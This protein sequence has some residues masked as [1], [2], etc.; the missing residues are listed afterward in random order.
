MA[1]ARKT[2]LSSSAV[3]SN[4]EQWAVNKAVHY[5]E[6]ANFGKNDF[7]PVVD[8][9]K[10]LLDCFRCTDCQSWLYITPRGGSPECSE[11]ELWTTGG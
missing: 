8:A 10:E 9:F 1:A 5:N 11:T 2:K 3:A 4:V 7:T 6:W